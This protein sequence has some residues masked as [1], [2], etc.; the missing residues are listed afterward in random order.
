MIRRVVFDMDNTLTDEMG[1]SL[2][3]GI[4]DLLEMLNAMGCEL[5]LWT[6]SSRERAREILRHHGLNK[7]FRRF[8]YREDYDP[9]NRGVRK[10]IRSIGG[11]LLIDDDP[12]EIEYVRSLGLKGYLLRPY[13][14]NAPLPPGEDG[15]IIAMVRGGLW[16]WLRGK[17]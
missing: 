6:N 16:E 10:D 7:Y 8:V 3:P 1:A 9:E 15:E 2:R 5:S 17:F 13:R 12:A 14:K 4:R 11:E